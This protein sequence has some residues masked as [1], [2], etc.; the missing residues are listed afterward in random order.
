MSSLPQKQ[1]I[2]SNPNILDPNNLQ[3]VKTALDRGLV[4][5][6]QYHSK[7]TTNLIFA[8]IDQYRQYLVQHSYPGDS[9]VLWSEADLLAQNK[10]LTIFVVGLPVTNVQVYQARLK[11]IENYV[12]GQPQ[13]TLIS[14]YRYGKSLENLHIETDNQAN[15]PKLLE[16]IENYLLQ[17]N[18]QITVFP[19][20]YI[21]NPHNIL[22]KA[23]YPNARRG[24][25]GGGNG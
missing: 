12:A 8:T 5:G 9:Y 6:F 23:T 17:P 25:L 4:F 18:Y 11:L 13:Q 19:L 21:D 20:T 16:I 14:L 2:N 7:A 3:K 22:V 24:V 1:V 15:N 10:Q